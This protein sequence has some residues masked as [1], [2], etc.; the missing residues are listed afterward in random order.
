MKLLAKVTTLEWHIGY[1]PKPKNTKDGEKQHQKD[2]LDAICIF[3]T[4]SY[5][6]VF[7]EAI[8]NSVVTRL[9]EF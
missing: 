6:N 2:L 3:D 1:K 4:H 5:E 8:Q 7:L 9:M